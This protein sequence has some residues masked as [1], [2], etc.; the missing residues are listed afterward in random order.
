MCSLVYSQNYKVSEEALLLIGLYIILLKVAIFSLDV[1][2]HY[3]VISDDLTLRL[4]QHINSCPEG[5]G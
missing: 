5:G 4:L 3:S 1:V 2:L